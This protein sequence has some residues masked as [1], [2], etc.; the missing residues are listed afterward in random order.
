MTEPVKML[1]VFLNDVDRL[2]GEPLYEVLLRRLRER[3]IAG[4]TVHHGTMGFGH[5]HRLHQKRLFGIADDKPVTITAID[6]ESRIRAIVPEVRAL[7]SEGLVLLVD[8][9]LV[10]DSPS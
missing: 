9:E 3:D 4:A 7:V 1:L 10:A 2:A 5:H 8:V 6:T